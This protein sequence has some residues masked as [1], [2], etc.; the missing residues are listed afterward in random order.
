MK[1]I[2]SIITLLFATSFAMA[3]NGKAITTHGKKFRETSVSIEINANE[4]KVWSLLTNAADFP[5]WNSTVTSIQGNIALDEKIKLKSILDQK[6]TFKLKVKEFDINK[7]M[8]WSDKQGQRVYTITKNTNGIITFKMSE[9]IGGF[10][11]PI[12]KNKIPSFDQF[13]KDLKQEA[14]KK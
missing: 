9:R 5:R 7:R 1:N 2:L 8:V 12:Y 11:F 14:E 4:T 6:R 3:Q 10:M 13:A